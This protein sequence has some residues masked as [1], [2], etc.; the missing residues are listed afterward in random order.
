VG[1]PFNAASWGERAF[2]AVALIGCGY[3]G[4]ACYATLN[5]APKK[6]FIPFIERTCARGDVHLWPRG[7]FGEDSEA[8]EYNDAYRAELSDELDQDISEDDMYHLEMR[9]DDFCKDHPDAPLGPV[10]QRAVAALN[11]K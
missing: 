6:S 3:I 2:G 10:V 4:Y 9:I 5:P 1:E 8:R 11:S 7:A